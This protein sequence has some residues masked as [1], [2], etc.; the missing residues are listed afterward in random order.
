MNI[1]AIRERVKAL[2]GQIT[3]LR[4]ANEAYLRKHIHSALETH[5]QLEREDRLQKILEELG[6]LMREKTG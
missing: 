4:E 3:P 6:H 1:S 5:A 2:Q